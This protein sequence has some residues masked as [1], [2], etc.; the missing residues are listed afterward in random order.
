MPLPVL[1]SHTPGHPVKTAGPVF[2][3]SGG[4]ISNKHALL[5]AGRRAC[6]V[7]FSACALEP[8]TSTYLR[9]PTSIFRK[10]TCIGLMSSGNN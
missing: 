6:E 5:F 2:V 9:I 8:A 7:R 4:V 10:V 3:A 1:R